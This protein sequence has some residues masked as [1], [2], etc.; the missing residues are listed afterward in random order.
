MN[1][2][3]KLRHFEPIERGTVNTKIHNGERE[4]FYLKMNVLSVVNSTVSESRP[5]GFST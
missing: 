2:L 3:A 5:R 4:P 1:Q